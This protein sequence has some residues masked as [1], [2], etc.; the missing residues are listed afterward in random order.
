[1]RALIE[2]RAVVAACLLAERTSQPIIA[3]AGWPIDGRVLCLIDPASG[4]HC[5]NPAV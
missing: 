2:D 3:D 4:D 1:M 5:P